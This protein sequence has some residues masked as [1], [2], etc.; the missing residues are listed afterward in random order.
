MTVETIRNRYCGPDYTVVTDNGTEYRIDFNRLFTATGLTCACGGSVV[1][2]LPDTRICAHI[3]A[4]REA[5]KG[6]AVIPYRK[7]A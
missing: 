5:S 4:R 2:G 6:G 3:V 7:E 1:D